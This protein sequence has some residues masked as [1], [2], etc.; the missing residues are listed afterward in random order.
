MAGSSVRWKAGRARLA[1]AALVAGGEPVRLVGGHREAAVGHAQRPGNVFCDIVVERLAGQHLHQVADHI[2]GHAVLPARAGRELQRQ[3][4][5]R[6][7]HRLQ[8]IARVDAGPVQ[9]VH[10]VAVHEAVG[11]ARGV[12]EQIL[13]DHFAVGRAGAVVVLAAAREHLQALPA[14]DVAA[15]RV[16]Q[17]ECAL[18]VE[19]HQRHAGDRLGHRV[20]ARD[21]VTLEAPP[22]FH[23]HQAAGEKQRLPS[24]PRDRQQVARQLAVVDVAAQHRLDPFEPL[25]RESVSHLRS[26]PHRAARGG[27]PEAVPRPRRRIAPGRLRSAGY[28]G[29]GS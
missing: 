5:Q 18:L 25:L 10:G 3:I 24:A 9:R 1:G 14:G 8:R 22:A 2:G 29:P 16:V 7:H 23:I 4:A 26:L 20:D 19:L 17:L 11:E 15:H 28:R 12:G 6:R 21:G 13:D 27:A